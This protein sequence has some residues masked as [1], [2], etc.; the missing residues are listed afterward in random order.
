MHPLVLTELFLFGLLVGSF[1]NVCIVRLPH[2][3]SIVRPRSH[4][5]KCRRMIPWYDNIPLVSYLAL[6][7]RCRSCHAPIPLQYPLVEALTGVMMVATYLKFGLSLPFGLYFFLLVAP[8]IVIT[9]IDLEHRIIPNVISLPGI[10]AGLVTVLLIGKEVVAMRLTQSLMGIVAGGGS[11]F[12][13]SWV[14]EKLRHREGIGMGDVKL[15]AMFGAFFGAQ[16]VLVILLLAS[17][18]GSV[19]GIFLMLF[20]RKGLKTAVP[21]GPFLAGG[22]LIYLFFG[23]ELLSWYLGRLSN[24]L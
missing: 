15:A 10:G 14:Y 12:L 13:V 5:R 11:L 22:A 1:L 21:F 19:V 20:F 3:E 23:S 8:L 4:C 7:G 18:F 24:S 9:L 6:R 17:F 2:R 16:G